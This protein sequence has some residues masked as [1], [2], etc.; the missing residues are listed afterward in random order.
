MNTMKTLAPKMFKNMITLEA[1][2]AHRAELK[3]DIAEWKL[4]GEDVTSLRVELKVLLGML[5]DAYTQ[6]HLLEEEQIL[7]E[8]R[9]VPYFNKMSLKQH[10]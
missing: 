5:E 3:R 4:E 7:V 1:L 2:N 9:Y 6:K 10:F 8:G